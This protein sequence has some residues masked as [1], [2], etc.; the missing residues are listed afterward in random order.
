MNDVFGLIGPKISILHNPSHP[1]RTIPRGWDDYNIIYSPEICTICC[2]EPPSFKEDIARLRVKPVIDLTQEKVDS[3][4]QD[5]DEKEAG[6]VTILPIQ[7]R[8]MKELN[9]LKKL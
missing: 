5:L 4:T 6:N 7:S 9:R 3:E 8:Q 2:S 1:N